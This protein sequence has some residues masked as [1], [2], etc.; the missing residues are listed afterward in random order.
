MLIKY[1]CN[2][3]NFDVNNAA[4]LF[5]ILFQKTNI[6]EISYIIISAG[7]VVCI[8]I[9]IYFEKEIITHL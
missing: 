6:C 2:D 5:Q 4:V 3:S 8:L 9:S 7:L 1:C